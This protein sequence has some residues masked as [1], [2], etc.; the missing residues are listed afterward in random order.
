MDWIE[1]QIQ[2]LQSSRQALAM[3]LAAI[4]ELLGEADAEIVRLNSLRSAHA[5]GRTGEHAVSTSL[6]GFRI[7]VI[8]PSYR[9]VDY[10]E[11]IQSLGARFSFAASEEKLGQIDRLCG[12]VDGVIFIT[13]FTS[14]KVEDHLAAASRRLGFPVYHLRLRGLERLREAAL[15]L[16]PQMQAY[17]S[18]VLADD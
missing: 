15:A 9:E 18:P 6:R 10:R 11:V 7:G 2:S 13:S 4:Q 8:G 1:E 3:E 5:G 17:R 14:H 12:K 16:L